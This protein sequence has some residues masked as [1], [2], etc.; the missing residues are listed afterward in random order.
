MD[1]LI[2]LKIVLPIF[3]IGIS[4]I[5][6]IKNILKKSNN[7][8]YDSKNNNLGLSIGLGLCFGTALAV[9]LSFENIGTGAGIGLGFGI[10]IGTIL[11]SN[12]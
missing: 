9:L 10:I 1:F 4:F 11:D 12:E 6:F 8:Q 5:F 3:L 7:A 2:I